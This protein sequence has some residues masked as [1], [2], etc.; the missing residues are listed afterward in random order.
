MLTILTWLWSTKYGDDYVRKLASG[1]CRH[2]KQPHQLLLVSDRKI[3]IDDVRNVAIPRQ[4][5]YLLHLPGCF[6]R[7]RMFDPAW[8]SSTQLHDRIVS[9]DLDV[10]ITGTLDPLFDRTEEFVIL[11]GANSEN[12][13]PYNGSCWMLQAGAHPEVWSEFTLE[14]ARGI[15]RHAFPD[16]QGWFWHMMPRA[17]GWKCG[18]ESGIFAYQKPGWPKGDALPNDAR[19]VV[20]P[21]WR[22]PGKFE[23]LDWV[24]EHWR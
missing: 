22:D 11:Q 13:N 19:M 12:P 20:F 7:L 23:H 2:L 24:R 8:Q 9:L 16:D 15:K 14:K 18:R 5:R 10:V 1:I 4:D 17:A 6:A 3:K 21:G